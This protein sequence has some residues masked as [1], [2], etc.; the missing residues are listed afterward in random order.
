MFAA[1]QPAIVAA[2]VMDS[3]ALAPSE[4]GTLTAPER[5]VRRLSN[6]QG[7]PTLSGVLCGG[8]NVEIQSDFGAGSLG[9]IRVSVV[10]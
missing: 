5:S 3:G 7:T 1:F 2:S 4:E 9:T 8:E 6:P 10:C